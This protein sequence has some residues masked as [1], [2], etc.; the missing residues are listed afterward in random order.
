MFYGLTL[1]NSGVS[2]C[3]DFSTQHWSFLTYLVPSGVTK[4]ITAITAAGVVTSAAHGYSDGDIVQL[5]GAGDFD[6]WQ[7]VSSVTTN[8]FTVQATGTAFS[9]IAS[10][11]KY[12]E[13]WFLIL[14]Q[15]EPTAQYM[16]HYSNGDLFVMDQTAYR[17]D[18]GPSLQSKNAE[19]RRRKFQ[20]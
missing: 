15:P 12:S 17:D 8:T 4:T 11:I 18:V 10:R 1:V 16:Q 19:V 6:G 13:S 7:V 20:A 5:L 2:L 14:H 3:Y 9:G